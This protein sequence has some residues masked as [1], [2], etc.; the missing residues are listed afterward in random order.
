[1][2]KTAE[3][4]Q[5]RLS[6]NRDTYSKK[7]QT[8]IQRV[9]LRDLKN[10]REQPKR[11]GNYPR[12]LFKIAANK[13]NHETS[14]KIKKNAANRSTA[15]ISNET[16]QERSRRFENAAK[17]YAAKKSSATPPERT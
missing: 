16:L 11:S 15:N 7:G 4:K 3:E 12:T 2:T 6:K 8:K 1:L 17:R 14:N 10:S 5:A 9:E 13:R